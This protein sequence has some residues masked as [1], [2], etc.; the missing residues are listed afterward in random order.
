[1]STARARGDI[2]QSKRQRIEFARE[3]AFENLFS[4]AINNPPDIRIASSERTIDVIE[5][6]GVGTIHEKTI[7]AVQEI[8]SS[9][10][11][12]RPIHGQL[13]VTRKNFFYNDVGRIIPLQALEIF[14]RVP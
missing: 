8:I 13:L 11:V 7:H 1:M 14:L 10:A 4:A 2:P 12:G 9:R 6:P 3:R 5:S